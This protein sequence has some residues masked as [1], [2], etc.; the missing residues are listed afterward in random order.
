MQCSF[1]SAMSRAGGFEFLND[2][3]QSGRRPN[4]DGTT[5]LRMAPYRG[6]RFVTAANFQLLVMPRPCLPYPCPRL[7]IIEPASSNGH[8]SA[9]ASS[10][11]A[12][13]DSRALAWSGSSA[14]LSVIATTQRLR[15]VRSG[16]ISRLF[17]FAQLSD[18]SNIEQRLC[19]R[20]CILVLSRPSPRL[21][22]VTESIVLPL[23]DQRASY[24]V[25]PTHQLRAQKHSGKQ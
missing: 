13:P 15:F 21:L 7:T 17:A 24:A 9:L 22:P 3:P 1:S 12:H 16:V 19:T 25:H 6:I 20:R 23:L 8:C 4:F 5:K 18:V 14:L 11:G 10:H 2:C